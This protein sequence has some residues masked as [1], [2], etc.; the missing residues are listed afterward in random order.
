[1]INQTLNGRR[2]ES[3]V[4]LRNRGLLEITVTNPLHPP[5]HP[6][7]PFAKMMLF[8]I[9]NVDDFNPFPFL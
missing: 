2:R 5:P 4:P 6:G 7:P 1:M 8:Q 9:F 3:D